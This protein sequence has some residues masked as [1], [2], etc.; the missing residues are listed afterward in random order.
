[1]KKNYTALDAL[2]GFMVALLS[3][4]TFTFLFM[5]VAMIIVMKKGDEQINLPQ[6]AGVLASLI[7]ELTFLISVP[8]VSKNK[9]TT[10]CLKL[11][12]K[13]KLKAILICILIGIIALFS[14]LP[15]NNLFLYF[16]EKIGYDTSTSSGIE[17]N[18]F[19]SLLLYLFILAI[20]PAFC[21]EIVFRGI[22]YNGLKEKGKIFSIL[23]SATMFMIIHMNFT[24][25]IYQFALGVIFAVVLNIT[26]SLWYT[27]IMHFFNNG[28]VLIITYFTSKI[29]V[30]E[31]T[32]TISFSGFWD[33]ALPFIFLLLGAFIIVDLFKKLSKTINSYTINNDSE[34]RIKSTQNLVLENDENHIVNNQEFLGQ[35]TLNLEFATQQKQLEDLIFKKN[36]IIYSIIT[37]IIYAIFALS[38]FA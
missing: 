3:Y 28:F 26:G 14:F 9:E 13:P 5:F 17:M 38:S 1:M 31:A 7:G 30:G 32:Q 35:E 23:I 37:L 22:C 8:L 29:D 27:M 20:V 12:K 16:L 11:N 36:F 18:N 33:Y 15:F 34:T 2:K 4:L 24:Q 6:Y 19:G 21:E 10:S 25:S